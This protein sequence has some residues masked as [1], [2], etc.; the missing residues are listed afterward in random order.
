MK[1]AISLLLLI[2]VMS[3]VFA[4]CSVEADNLIG[5]WKADSIEADGVKYTISEIE[6]MGD[7]SMSEAQIIIKDGGKALLSDG[8][9]SDIVNW[10]K[11]ST[12]IK[13]GVENCAI[14]DGM[15]RIEYGECYI[16]FAKISDSQTVDDTQDSDDTQTPS[17][18]ED[19]E[20]EQESDLSVVDKDSPSEVTGTWIA[21][22]IEADGVKYTIPEIEAMGDDSMSDIQIVIKDG[23]KACL[24]DSVS[25][26]IVDWEKTDSGIKIGKADCTIV[27]GMICLEYGECYVYFIKISDSQ[28][29]GA[30]QNGNGTQDMDE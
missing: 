20:Q 21:D 27:D 26:D 7:D 6:A 29:I 19:S 12:G 3:T 30:T 25:S 23:G 1:K 18:E 22:S 16:Y 24:I 14:V 28:I 11:T 5:T 13:I 4:G 15:I 17:T 9:S 2:A 8:V 10:K